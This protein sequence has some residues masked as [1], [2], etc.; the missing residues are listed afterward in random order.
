MTIK[1]ILIFFPLILILFLIQSFF[2][3]TTYEK[4][5]DGNPARLL[6]YIQASSGDAQILNLIL[7]ADTSSSTINNLVFDGLI[8]LDKDLNYRPRLAKSWLQYEEAYLAINLSWL[9]PGIGVVN[10]PNEW[11]FVLLNSI[12]S[13]IEWRNNIQKI[14]IVEPEI[15]QK[16]FENIEYI[17]KQPPN[18]DRTLYM[19]TIDKTVRF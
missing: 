16:K 13:D 18:M 10:N 9:F 15:I 3:V 5:E 17:Y 2:W 4:Q 11:S 12:S 14:E 6:K 1:N 7:S 19:S 8:D